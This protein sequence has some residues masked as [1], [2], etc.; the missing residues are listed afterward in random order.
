MRKLI[1]LCTAILIAS[2]L[3][4]PATL[5]VGCQ[6]QAEPVPAPSAESLPSPTP[7]P[8][9]SPMADKVNP[10]VAKK[11]VMNELRDLL[12]KRKRQLDNE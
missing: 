5:M 8:A 6:Q 10:A 4:L 11:E 2:L 12:E 7:A 1:I 9:P 3:A